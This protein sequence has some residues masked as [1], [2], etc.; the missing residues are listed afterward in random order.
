MLETFRAHNASKTPYTQNA[1]IITA[2]VASAQY[3]NY[4][5]WELEY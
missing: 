4:T 1:I 3:K 5:C 2:G